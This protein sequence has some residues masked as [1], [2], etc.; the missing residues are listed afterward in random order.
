MENEF[1]L[2]IKNVTK[3]FPGVVALR[4]VSISMK[5]GEVLAICGENGAGKTTLM[6]ILSGSYPSKE[7]EGEIWID[8]EKVDFK[9]YNREIAR[10]L[11][12]HVTADE[13]ETLT[14][15]VKIFDIEFN[16]AI[17][18]LGSDK[19]R[20][21]AIAAQT[22]RIIRER[23]QTD[24]AFYQRFSDRIKEILENMHLSKIE[25]AEALKQLRIVS[26][27]VQIK[28]DDR[29][30]QAIA[31]TRGADILWRNMRDTVGTSVNKYEEI[32]VGLA[33]EIRANALVDWYR[34]HETKRQ[35][36]EQLD[37][38]LYSVRDM[39]DYDTADKIIDEAM[40]LAE[41]N[42]EEFRSHA[43]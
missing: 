23:Y 10:I 3:R 27:E 26:K 36:R 4:N 43:K 42:H 40:K 11:D 15:E 34:N 39:V 12:Q 18:D 21:E 20:A 31:E 41:F 29:L 5:P 28:K 13:I 16:A 7:Y 38:Y 14:D 25:D 8:G 22:T 6:K 19:S 30:P 9:K 33:N 17:D 37:D 32:V 35:M 24:Q 2:Q 1:I